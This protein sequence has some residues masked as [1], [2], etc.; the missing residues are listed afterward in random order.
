MRGERKMRRLAGM[1]AICVALGAVPAL[2]EPQRVAEHDT[3]NA[4]LWMQSSAEYQAA[5]LSAYAMARAALDRALADPAWTAALEQDGGAAGKP[6]AVILDLDETVFDNTPYY[7]WLIASGA[8]ASAQTFSDFIEEKVSPPVPGAVDY[9]KYAASRGVALF[10][11]SNRNAALKATSLEALAALGVK[12]GE[13][14][15]LLK[16]ERR[17]WAVQKG[18]RRAVVAERYRIVQ[19][20]GDALGDFVD[21]YGVTIRRR[22][23]EVRSHADRWG[24]KWIM[25]PNPVYGNWENAAYEYNVKLDEQGRR[26]EKLRALVPWK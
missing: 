16:R 10:F 15:I 20:V 22:G 1:V 4:L 5:A 21:D 3:L 8:P 23:Q 2:A 13:E 17:D 19:I 11:V 12:V 18:S 14:N 24:S 26:A 7:A 6:P 9:M 25:L